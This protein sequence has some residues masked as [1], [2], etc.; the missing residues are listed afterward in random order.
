[1]AIAEPLAAFWPLVTSVS[2]LVTESTVFAFSALIYLLVSV[3]MSGPLGSGGL[4][5]L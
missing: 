4:M 5:K 2:D 3:F 1:L